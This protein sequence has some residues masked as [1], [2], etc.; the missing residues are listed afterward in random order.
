VSDDPIMNMRGRAQQCR[1]LA[2]SIADRKTVGV[3]LQMANDIEK[4]IKRLEKER[5]D[6][7]A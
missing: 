5:A 1:R 4:D 6:H 7:G 2:H 3:L